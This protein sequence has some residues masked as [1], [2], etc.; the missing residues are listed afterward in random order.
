MAYMPP[1]LSAQAPPQEM[2]PEQTPVSLGSL[3]P[4]APSKEFQRMAEEYVKDFCRA[5]SSYIRDQIAHWKLLHQL[6]ENKIGLRE[7]ANGTDGGLSTS[8]SRIR[9]D[10]ETEPTWY[11]DLVYT[12]RH[13]NEAVTANVF[14]AI[15]DGPDYVTIGLKENRNPNEGTTNAGADQSQTSFP[16]AMRM[17]ELLKSFLKS[18]QIHARMTDCLIEWGKLGTLAG[19]VSW[20]ERTTLKWVKAPDGKR[21]RERVVLDQFPVIH[22]IPLENFLPDPCALSNDVRLWR[23]V[24]HKVERTYDQILDGFR[25]GMYSLNEAEFKKTLS[26]K[27]GTPIPQPNPVTGELRAGQ[28]EENITRLFVWEVHGQIPSP[29]GYLEGVCSI[30][31]DLAAENPASGL[32]IRLSDE[33]ALESGE[34]PIQV[35]HFCQRP[36]PLGAGLIDANEDLIYAISQ[37]INQLQDN[38]RLCA[39]GAWTAPE[40]SKQELWIQDNGGTIFPGAIIPK[41]QFTA[42]NGLEPVTM[43]VFSP[44]VILE[45]ISFLIQ[46]LE[47]RTVTETFQGT[48]SKRQTATE[49]SM[50][51]Q[52]SQRPVQFRTDL[53]ART[54]IEP[55]FNICLSMVCQ[56]AVGDQTVYVRNPSGQIVPATITQQELRD[57]KY[58]VTT[59]LTRQDSSKIARMQS[60]ERILPI[61]AQMESLIMRDGRRVSFSELIQRHLDSTGMDG[62]DRVLV[63]L[64]EEEK[65]QMAMAQQQPPGGPPQGPNGPPQGAPP[66]GPPQGGPPEPPQMGPGGG[67]I[68]GGGDTDANAQLLQNFALQMQGGGA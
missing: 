8:Q 32:M 10:D 23:M 26:P 41:D 63:A 58:V 18:G 21:T 54:F 38:T 39:I 31:T 49:A 43:P 24:G 9:D 5:S 19:K 55:V 35:A 44:Q 17:E 11:S 40:G 65:A 14:G 34:R 64:S 46:L 22:P 2:Q 13:L 3:P 53:L 7:W 15:F 33:P 47:R 45:V 61:L 36:G 56:F 67:P 68:G 50:L 4:P 51:Q 1:D 66:A 20:H 62:V 16:L 42:G 12:P 6:Y 52:Q 59:T 27:G 57:H 60:I 48:N 30:V 29:D 28:D 25:S 37:F